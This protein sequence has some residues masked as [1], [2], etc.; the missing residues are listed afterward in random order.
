[1]EEEVELPEEYERVEESIKELE[2]EGVEITPKSIAMK[3]LEK[4]GIDISDDQLD[5]IIETLYLV[6]NVVTH[7][8]E[9][10]QLEE[11]DD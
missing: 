11:K 5:N 7:M 4:E 1:M 10:G 2:M 8:D 3:C 6:D 9:V